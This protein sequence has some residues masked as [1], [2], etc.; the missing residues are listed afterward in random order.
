MTRKA[1][2]K[3]PKSEHHPLWDRFIGTLLAHAVIWIIKRIWN[4][5]DPWI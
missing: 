1:S 2:P 3:K 4:W 5:L